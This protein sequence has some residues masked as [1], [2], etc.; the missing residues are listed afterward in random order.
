M[1][2]LVR[3][4]FFVALPIAWAET[5]AVMLQA[6][7]GANGE[8]TIQASSPRAGLQL[9]PILAAVIHC[10][11]RATLDADMF[12]ESHCHHAL[13]RDGLALEGVFDLAPIAQKLAPTDEIQFLVEYPRLGFESSSTLLEDEGSRSRS[14]QTARFTAG[15]APA[16][17]RIRFG[18]HADQLVVVYFPLLAMA[19]ALIL[20][21]MGLSRAGRVDLGRSVF[22]LGT[23]FW[24]GVVT[25]LQ[26][27]EPLRIL[28]SGT[29]VSNIAATLLEYFPPL[30]CVAA[31]VALG[32]AKQTDR[33]PSEMFAEVFWGFGML[34][35]PLAGSLAAVPLMVEGDWIRG[36]PWLIFATVSV[37]ACRWRIRA[38]AQTTIRELSVGE[39]KDRVSQM[40]A[41]MGAGA[42]R[43]FVSSSARSQTS[44]AFAMR[45]SSIVLTAPLIQS[46]SKREVDAV[47]AHE[48]SHFGHTRRSP[49]AALALAAILFEK[50][51]A[52]ITLDT[53]G[54]VFVGVLL[55][56]VLVYFAALRGARKREFA[57]DA[58]SVALT[59][60]PRA[61]ISALARIARD[62]RTPLDFSVVAEWFSTH[63]ST[64]RRIRALAAAARLETAE[65]EALCN[66]G[67]PG[68]PYALPP[69]KNDAIF[70]LGWQ[71]TNATRYVWTALIA[72]SGA[73]LLVA[74]LLDKFAEAAFA[75]LVGGVVIGCAVTKVLAATVMSINYARLRRKLATKLNACGQLVGL[76][77]DS[78]PRVYNG[79]RFSDVGFVSFQGGR[80]CYRSESISIELNPADVEEVSMVAAAPASWRR[81]QPMVRFLDHD[82]GD[83]KAFILHPVEWG[84]TPRR[85]FRSILRWKET[86]SSAESTSI[87]GLNAVAGQPYRVPNIAQTA[88]GFRIPGFITLVG[89]T[90]AGW[91]VR[92]DSWLAWY[93]LAITACSYTFM[94]LPAMLYRPSRLPPVLAPRVD[95]E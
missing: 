45:R 54:G 85:L 26:A 20:I 82:S 80:L 48:L 51:L 13:R 15:A 52:D 31:G 44:N 11:G 16:P 6:R 10:Q 35:F 70:T 4:L 56:P 9:A 32:G 37:I 46:I 40:A 72:A 21:A 92:G 68:A 30:L 59:G 41:K 58:G 73:G 33:R 34:L 77:V 86:A 87:Q 28:L 88:R 90:L 93:A 69:E 81:F 47:V 23:M 75:Q 49:W 38:S 63:P 89:A 25:R 55:V 79:Y 61:M 71:T 91:F 66:N 17:I 7:M 5:P 43:V 83:V 19:L 62:N 14:T 67:D 1:G 3:A 78:Q 60:D 53:A 95:A 42:V 12:G 27:A 8:V 39:L 18:Y 94:Y 65:M 50:P 24:L 57:A 29:P 84:A 76:A 22:L 36:I 74:S 64:H 2:A